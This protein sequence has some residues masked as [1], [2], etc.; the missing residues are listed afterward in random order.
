M[1][2]IYPSHYQRRWVLIIYGYYIDGLSLEEID[3]KL[4]LH[5]NKNFPIED[6]DAI[7]DWVNLLYF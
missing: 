4:S 7:I 1:K 2:N 5:Y 6:I 3:E